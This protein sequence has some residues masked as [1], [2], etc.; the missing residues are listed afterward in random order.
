MGACG[1]SK[2]WFCA[3]MRFTWNNSESS[4]GSSWEIRCCHLQLG[5]APHLPL[6]L[7]LSTEDAEEA[8]LN[9]CVG[10]MLRFAITLKKKFNSSTLVWLLLKRKGKEVFCENLLGNESVVTDSKQLKYKNKQTSRTRHLILLF[11]LSMPL[12]CASKLLQVRAIEKKVSEACRVLSL[13][14]YPNNQCKIWLLL[15]MLV[16]V[17]HA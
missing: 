2:Q 15:Q 11:F 13:Q 3:G 17:T 16:C 10:F 5:V 8:D 7:K 9:I 14:D 6:Y 12:Y 4:S 1:K